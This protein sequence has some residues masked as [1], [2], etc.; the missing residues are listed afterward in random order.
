MRDAVGDD[1]GRWPAGEPGFWRQVVEQLGTALLV[2]DA[3]GRVIAA[4]P[5]AER[6][7]GRTTAAMR[8]ADAHD[9]LHRDADGNKVPRDRCPCSTRWPRGRTRKGRVAHICGMTVAC[10]LS[11]GPRPP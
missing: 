10:W 8:G 11:P 4:N 3:A 9:L 2:L 6:L 1:V 7:L 5:A